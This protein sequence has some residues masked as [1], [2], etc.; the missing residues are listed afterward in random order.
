MFVGDFSK[1]IGLFLLAFGVGAVI[2][3]FLP[4]WLWVL[5]VAAVLMILGFIWLIC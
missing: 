4:L 3:L 2:T 5:I 1:A